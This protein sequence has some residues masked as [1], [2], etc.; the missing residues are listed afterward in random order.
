MNSLK[1][2]SFGIYKDNQNPIN[3]IYNNDEVLYMDGCFWDTNTQVFGYLNGYKGKTENE[4]ISYY[5]LICKKRLDLKYRII[6]APEYM[7]N[8]IP[9]MDKHNELYK[10][11]VNIKESGMETQTS[12][13]ILIIT[14]D[15]NMKQKMLVS[16][17]QYQ[18][19]YSNMNGMIILL[20]LGFQKREKMLRMKKENTIW[21]EAC[22]LFII[23]K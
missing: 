13:C 4:L 8:I 1:V 17:S 12:I 2:I 14:T 6:S 10:R 9:I 7:K 15:T 11:L 16:I 18:I 22:Y 20:E 3:Q 19:F 23:K 21:K 5:E